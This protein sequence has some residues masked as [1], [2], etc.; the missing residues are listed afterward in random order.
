[1]MKCSTALLKALTPTCTKQ[2]K[3]KDTLYS[4]CLPVL[5]HNSQN[6]VLPLSSWS[7]GRAFSCLPL[8]AAGR[9]H[10]QFLGESISAQALWCFCMGT[11]SCQTPGILPGSGTS[12]SWLQQSQDTVVSVYWYG[13][14][15]YTFKKLLTVFFWNDQNFL[16]MPRECEAGI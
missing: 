7:K 10:Q 9:S 14:T 12:C 8:H 4:G 11:S 3:Q 5:E 1:M 16:L 15:V 13:L 6:H 2:H